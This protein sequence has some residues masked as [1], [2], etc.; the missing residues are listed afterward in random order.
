MN[1]FLCKSQWRSNKL[2]NNE[3]SVQFHKQQRYLISVC[4]CVCVCVCERERERK[5]QG[6]RAL[7]NSHTCCQVII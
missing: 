3:S 2:P 5:K 7:A 1:G 6:G 4:V